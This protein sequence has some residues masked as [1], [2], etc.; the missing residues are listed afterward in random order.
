[1]RNTLTKVR[2]TNGIAFRI[3][4][5]AFAAALTRSGGE[6]SDSLYARLCLALGNVANVEI[7]RGRSGKWYV[8]PVVKGAVTTPRF[9]VF[10]HMDE[11][12]DP[13][14]IREFHTLDA[15][16]K[17]MREQELCT[18][19]DIAYWAEDSTDNAVFDSC[20]RIKGDT[21]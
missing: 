10:G 19:P 2:N 5:P 13:Q 21:F 20:T 18:H 16:V 1:M 8:R 15:A 17:F 6:A 9:M 7:A 14:E 12:G 3:D 11:C 4:A